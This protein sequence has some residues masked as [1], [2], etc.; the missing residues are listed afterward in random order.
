M[1]RLY[2]FNSIFRPVLCGIDYIKQGMSA[3]PNGSPKLDEAVFGEIQVLLAEKR[4]AQG[5]ECAQQAPTPT[6]GNS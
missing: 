5:S 2:E 3:E 4:S 6:G 1:R